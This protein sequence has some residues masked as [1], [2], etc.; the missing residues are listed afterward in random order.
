[1]NAILQISEKARELVGATNAPVV[2]FMGTCAVGPPSGRSLREIAA[3]DRSVTPARK[4]R[5]RSV[6]AYEAFIAHHGS[7]RKEP[8]T[9]I[10]EVEDSFCHLCANHVFTMFSSHSKKSIRTTKIKMV[11]LF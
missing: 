6:L 5:F 9:L 10:G 3:V 4:E 11:S 2:K 7:R 8:C 1:M